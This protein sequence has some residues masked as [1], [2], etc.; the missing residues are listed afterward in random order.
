[1]FCLLCSICFQRKR[2][3][4]CDDVFFASTFYAIMLKDLKIVGL[5][6]V[7]GGARCGNLAALPKAS[8]IQTEVAHIGRFAALEIEEGHA[9]C[10][11]IHEENEHISLDF[12]ADA[13]H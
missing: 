4:S 3:M 11:N 1:M 13:M 9:K 10:P 7:D 2:E 6:T 5:D 8:I 12:I